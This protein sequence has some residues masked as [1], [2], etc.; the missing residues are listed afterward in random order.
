MPAAQGGVSGQMEKRFPGQ[1]DFKRKPWCEAPGEQ[2]LEQ[3]EED[4][5][6]KA[7]SHRW[8]FCSLRGTVLPL[9]IPVWFGAKKIKNSNKK[10][11][12]NM[13]CA[14]IAVMFQTEVRSGF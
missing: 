12:I 7:D 9:S 8:V 6:L 5:S 14:G 2:R 11:K 10:K 3:K 1:A 13:N 4:S